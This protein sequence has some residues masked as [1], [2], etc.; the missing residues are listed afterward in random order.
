MTYAEKHIIA[1][2]SKLLGNLSDAGK[3]ELIRTLSK[4]KKKEEKKK[5]E[6]FYKSFGAFDSEKSAEEIIHEIKSNRR[7]RSKEIEF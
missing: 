4:S 1:S 3:S 6:R 5:E 2:Y 7:F